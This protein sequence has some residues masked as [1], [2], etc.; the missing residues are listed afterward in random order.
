MVE[1]YSKKNFVNQSQPRSIVIQRILAFSK[2]YLHTKVQYDD[3]VKKSNS[4]A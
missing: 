4:S 1:N 3:I 2:F